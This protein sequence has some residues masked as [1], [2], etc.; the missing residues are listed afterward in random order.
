VSSNGNSSG[1]VWA[2]QTD[3]YNSSPGPAILRAYNATNITN[4]LYDS[5]QNPARDTAG[6]ATKFVVPTI[7][8]SRVYFGT[9]AELDV[10]GLLNITPTAATPVISP[11]SQTF[12]G[13]LSVTITDSTAGATIYYTTDGSTPT[14]SSTTYSGPIAV[15]TTET[16]TAIA[17][18]TGFLQSLA[19][20]QTYNLQNQVT[21]PTFSPP[22]SSFSSPI[23]VT[24]S[25]S[26][27][28]ARIYY[29]TNGTVP[30]TSSAL[31]APIAVAPPP[32]QYHRR[33]QRRGQLNVS[34][35]RMHSRREPA[36]TF[37]QFSTATSLMTFNGSTGLADT[38]CSPMAEPRRRAA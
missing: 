25:D 30:T 5:T 16:I 24:L 21:A 31:F 3:A 11:A 13:T 12:S 37:Q 36:Q 8:N 2:V 28:G 38:V 17:S 19:A 1:I 18:A 7:A 26:T 20:S 29:T 6:Q 10:Y 15:S 23:S 32:H 4:E 9:A 27:A 14:T 33:G 35:Q 34:A 22:S